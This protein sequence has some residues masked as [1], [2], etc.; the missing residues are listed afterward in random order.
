MR[1]GKLPIHVK[2]GTR[3]PAALALLR[4]ARGSA[5]PGTA[6]APRAAPSAAAGSWHR[7]GQRGQSGTGVPSTG[8]DP[9]H[10]RPATARRASPAALP[11]PPCSA[12]AQRLGAGR[13]GAPALW[14]G[15]AMGALSVPGAAEHLSAARSCP[16]RVG[17]PAAAPAGPALA[18]AGQ[19]AAR[20]NIL[21]GQVLP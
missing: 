4:G 19:T 8:G 2:S 5:P 11:V 18:A 13:K 3:H 6:A 10:P 9:A 12:S 15:G 17:V 16:P 7:A 1:A 20:A 14:G 21:S